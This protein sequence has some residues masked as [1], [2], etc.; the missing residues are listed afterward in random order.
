MTKGLLF[1]AAVLVGVA[2]WAC[3]SQPEPPE[4]ESKRQIIRAESLNR[5]DDLDGLLNHLMDAPGAST[6]DSTDVLVQSPCPCSEIPKPWAEPMPMADEFAE[7]TAAQCNDGERVVIYK[8][9]PH[10]GKRWCEPK[11]PR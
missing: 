4:G 3:Q 2:S 10:T 9:R 11:Y 6:D 7:V 8:Y 1:A 5:S